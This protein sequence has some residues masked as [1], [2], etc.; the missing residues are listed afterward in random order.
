MLT[1]AREATVARVGRSFC[2]AMTTPLSRESY[3]P[4][5]VCARATDRN[6]DNRWPAEERRMSGDQHLPD[7]KMSPI[8]ASVHGV[9]D[10]HC[11]AI[12]DDFET[13]HEVGIRL[14]T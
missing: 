4:L 10:A 14:A 13:I 3:G 11:E 6:D 12:E 2:F 9:G 7:R 5:A 8:P 1:P